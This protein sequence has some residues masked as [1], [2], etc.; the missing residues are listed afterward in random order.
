MEKLLP[1]KAKFILAKKGTGLTLDEAT[2]VAASY[3]HPDPVM[4]NQA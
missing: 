4:L 3:L 1:K 2:I